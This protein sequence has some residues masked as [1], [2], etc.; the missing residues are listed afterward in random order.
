M[1][2][3]IVLLL[4]LALV[5]PAAAETFWLTGLNDDYP[6]SDVERVESLDLRPLYR[7]LTQVTFHA[8]TAL[9]AGQLQDPQGNPHPWAGWPTLAFEVGGVV[10]ATSERPYLMG[11]D[12][13]YHAG[14]EFTEGHHGTDLLTGPLT[15][16]MVCLGEPL[17][18]PLFVPVQDPGMQL[19]DA[20]L[21]VEGMVVANEQATW[22]AVKHL[23][24]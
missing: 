12:G 8:W 18:D 3:L 5:S 7:R 9:T 14:I 6:D 20:R 21:D 10:V 11:P 16:R 22:S 17:S 2:R 1:T 4:L 19:A 13:Q 24:R 15:L 23:Y